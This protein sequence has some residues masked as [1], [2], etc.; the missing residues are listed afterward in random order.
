MKNFGLLLPRAGACAYEH[1]YPN[2]KHLSFGQ[3]NVSNE[4]LRSSSMTNRGFAPSLY[5]CHSRIE[6]GAAGDNFVVMG[7]DGS[8]YGYVCNLTDARVI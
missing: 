6:H 7:A 2:E 3:K 1:L 5:V 8:L 4:K